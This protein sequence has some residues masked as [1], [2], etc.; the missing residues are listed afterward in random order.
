VRKLTRKRFSQKKA[1]LPE[2]Q[3]M[4]AGDALSEQHASNMLSQMT[5]DLGFG[6]GF[7][8]GKGGLLLLLLKNLLLAER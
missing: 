4:F 3:K 1:P 7:P 6:V 2:M 5:S 8:S